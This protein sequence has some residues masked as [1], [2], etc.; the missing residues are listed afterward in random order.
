[1]PTVRLDSHESEALH[2]RLNFIVAKYALN[3]KMIEEESRV[4]AETI[5]KIKDKV[6]LI[7]AY[8]TILDNKH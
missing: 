6:A 3:A 2:R 7:K 8:Q 5:Q 1:M 4:L